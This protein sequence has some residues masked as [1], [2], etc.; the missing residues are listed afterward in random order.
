MKYGIDAS[1][2]KTPSTSRPAP[3]PPFWLMNDTA[4]ATMNPPTIRT[5]GS[6]RATNRSR[7]RT[8]T[9]IVATPERHAHPNPKGR[10]ASSFAV[11]ALHLEVQLVAPLAVAPRRHDHCA[12]GRGRREM[13]HMDFIA[14]RCL[15][16]G[17]AGVLSSDGR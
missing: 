3:A 4:V 14:D 9:H 8:I 16:L 7:K 13:P 12:A 6:A 17:A 1:A 11:A 5:A 15:A 10:S 2:N